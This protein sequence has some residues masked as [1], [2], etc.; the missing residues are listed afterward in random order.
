V[1]IRQLLTENLMV[2]LLG[3]AGGALL[4][5]WIMGA[6]AGWHP[7]VDIP[8]VVS[9]PV[10]MRVFLFALVVSAVTALLFGLLPALQATKNGLGPGI[11]E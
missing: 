3:G 10:D 4:A 1:L 8:L 7:P 5:V 2:A 11:E 6:L 9:V